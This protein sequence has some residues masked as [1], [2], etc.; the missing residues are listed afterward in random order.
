MRTGFRTIVAALLACVVCAATAAAAPSAVDRAAKSAVVVK[1]GSF[2]A[3]AFAVDNR[4]GF[5]T[6]EQ[7]A[8]RGTDIT[9]E[10]PDGSELPAVREESTAPAGLALLRVR[11]AGPELE[12]LVVAVKEAQPGDRVWVAPAPQV[13]P[14][15]P[16]TVAELPLAFE[17]SEG[18][19][20][21]DRARRNGITGSPVLSSV[22]EVVAAV[23]ASRGSL[24]ERRIQ[25]VS[26]TEQPEALPA[27]KPPKKNDFPA[28]PVVVGIGALL[29]LLNI[30]FTVR[31][32]REARDVIVAARTPGEVPTAPAPAPEPLDDLEVTLKR[33]RPAGPPPSDDSGD[34]DLVTLK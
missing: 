10:F 20:F 23:R 13:G 8:S 25:A 2:S 33:D 15:R 11:G 12:P 7:A 4:G 6:T 27:I 30:L 9:I 29:L 28:V 32:R 18:L 26:I 22:G 14:P 5:L 3:V 17:K 16:A 19:L 1:R 21:L 31:R 34:S 24:R